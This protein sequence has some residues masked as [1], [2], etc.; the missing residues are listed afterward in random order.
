MEFKNKTFCISLIINKMQKTLVSVEVI[1]F[2]ISTKFQKKSLMIKI[3]NKVLRLF[4]EN[5]T[6]KCLS[7]ST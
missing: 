7:S 5:L 6:W 3:K 4:L 2:K 1:F